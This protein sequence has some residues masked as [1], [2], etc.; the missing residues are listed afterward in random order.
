MKE[1]T[2]KATE[3]TRGFHPDGYRIDKSAAPLD[4]YTQWKINADGQ[5]IESKPTCF[6]SLPADG[7]YKD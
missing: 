2:F 4:Y 7:W 3:I 6:H 1:Q 5:W